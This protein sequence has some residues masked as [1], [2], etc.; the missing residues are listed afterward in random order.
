MEWHQQGFSSLQ[1]WLN[2]IAFLPMPWL[3]L[4]LYAVQDP[5]PNVMALTGAL[6]YGVAF[7]YFAHS[8]L[9]AIAE[10][11]PSYE[12][13][14]SRLGGLYTLH[15]GLMV[16]GGIMFA[17]SS[18]RRNRLP[19]WALLLFGAG[20]ACNLVVALVPAPDIYQT[21]GSRVRNLGLM[22]MGYSVLVGARRFA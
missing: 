12:A 1:L 5:C 4:G 21:I 17:W 18:F 15:G 6:I 3:L 13:L 19:R 22:G 10:H 2:Y 14:W 7:T 9:Y 16:L 20:V 8:T 11:V